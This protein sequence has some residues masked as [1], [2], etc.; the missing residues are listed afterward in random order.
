MIETVVEVAW[1][2]VAV[3][4][5]GSVPKVSFTLSP[6]SSSVSSMA[7]NV[8]VRDVSVAPKVTLAGTPE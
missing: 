5:F 1:P 8:I 6:S 4:P 7:V 2:L 3:T